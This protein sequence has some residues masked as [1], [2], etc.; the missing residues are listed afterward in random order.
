M[1]NSGS[2]VVVMFDSS[3]GNERIVRDF[4]NPT[5]TPNGLGLD[6]GSLW[7][8]VD[9]NDR[10]E[11]LSLTTFE[12]ETAIN[13]SNLAGQTLQGLWLRDGALY[14]TKNGGGASN[15]AIEKFSTSGTRQ[16]APFI[17]DTLG[18]CNFN[19]ARKVTTLPSGV[20]VSTS[21]GSNQVFL[22]SSTGASCTSAVTLVGCTGPY[23]VA[24]HSATSKI[25]VSCNTNSAI[26]ALA[27]DG[28]GEATV[29]SNTGVISTPTDLAVDSAGYVYIANTGLDTLEKFSFDG[30]TLTRATSTPFINPSVYMRDPVSVVVMP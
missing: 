24:Y 6:S 8:A 1:G 28:S 11:K 20:V 2:N 21:A 10:V 5:E 12:A 7:I 3:G 29:F 16:G 13:N 27:A 30:T 19:I 15:N 23:G 22:Y 25:L 17:A 18:S 26:V 4:N 9:G 14:M